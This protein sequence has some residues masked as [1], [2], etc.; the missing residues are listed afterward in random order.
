M[1]ALG[2]IEGYLTTHQEVSRV[3]L[4][5]EPDPERITQ[6]QSMVEKTGLR[7]THLHTEHRGDRVVV[8]IA[9][10]GPK[11]N[12]ARA[13]EGLLRSARSLTVDDQE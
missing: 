3:T 7:I 1:S 8:E 2:R 4:E 6:L 5:V 13:R 12:H 9:M 10:R 11:E